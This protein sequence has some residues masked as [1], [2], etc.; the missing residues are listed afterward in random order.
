MG[1]LIIRIFLFALIS[2][3]PFLFP[4]QSSAVIL[5]DRVNAGSPFSATSGNPNED[6]PVSQFE[7]SADEL[8]LG[9]AD[10]GF[11]KTPGFGEGLPV[12]REGGTPVSRLNMN[13]VPSSLARSAVQEV[14]IIAG[15]LG[16]F[17][18]TI[19]LAKNIPV[20]LFITD[21]SK[22]SLCIMMDDFQIRKQLHSHKVE[23][24]SF[25]PVT[26]GQYRFYCPVNGM[27]GNLLVKD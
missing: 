2:L 8:T 6:F 4:T 24:I 14:A 22:K 13:R 23:E 5:A 21:V 11:Q 12:I 17:P 19:L 3:S 20:R 15:D 16:Y 18:K 10:I 26:S 1:K 25:T 7:S 9:S 27:E